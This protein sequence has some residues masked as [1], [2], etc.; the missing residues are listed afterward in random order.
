MKGWFIT[1]EGCDGCGKSTQLT[2]LREY[3][4]AAN[5]PFIFT[6]EPGGG[7]ISEG[8][9]EILLNGKNAE[10]SDECEALLY[11]A[12]RAQHIR[13]RVAPALEEGKVVVCD[14]Y[15]DSSF[16]YQAHA[17]G[18]GMEFVSK[19][20]AFALES[21]LPDLTFFIDLSPEE[22]FIRK[23]GADANDRIEQAGIEFHNRVY[24]GYL[25]VA[26]ANPDR[27]VVLNGRQTIDEIAADVRK[28]LETKG[29]VCLK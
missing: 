14:R 7:K 22:A 20:N 13:D 8:I 26:K 1:F 18:L 23:R 19:I 17:R 25:S 10:M 6:R 15:V 27:F 3:L 24:Q 4:E 5:V 21:F 11:A 2:R 28:A 12:S 16:A 29:I 9:R